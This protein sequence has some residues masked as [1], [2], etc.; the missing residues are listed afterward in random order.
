MRLS[1]LTPLLISP[2]FGQLLVRDGK[3]IVD[4]L[5]TLSDRLT[6]MDST[7]DK[8]N[9]ESNID[10][11]KDFQNQATELG[12]EIQTATDAAKESAALNDDESASVAYAVVDLTDGIYSVLDKTAEKRAVFDKITV[13]DKPATELV[14]TE[15]QN[16]QN[17]TDAF[18]ETLTVKFVEDIKNVAPLLVSAIDFHFYQALQSYA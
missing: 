18:G 14:K 5:S 13:D 17:A 7:L 4:A 12:K 8:I 2:V 1:V 9:D 11:A 15:L 6:T 10:A 16:L 3:T